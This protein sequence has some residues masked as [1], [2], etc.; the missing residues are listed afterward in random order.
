MVELEQEEIDGEEH[1]GEVTLLEPFFD[2]H[3]Y[4]G[5]PTVNTFE[6]EFDHVTGYLEG[7]GFGL[8]VQ[9]ILEDV[10]EIVEVGLFG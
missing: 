3:L 10:E 4:E 5:I 9:E 8:L 6:L 7:L 2:D 1:Y